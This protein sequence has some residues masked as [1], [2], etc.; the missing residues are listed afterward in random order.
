MDDQ[1]SS[2]SGDSTKRFSAKRKLA[3][4]QR[5]VRGQS[6]EAVSRNLNVPFHQ[7]SEW[8]DKVLL[9]AESALRERGRDA[10]DDEIA[11]LQAKVAEY[12]SAVH[13]PLRRSFTLSDYDISDERTSCVRKP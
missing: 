1:N 10:R 7:V 9:G 6:L 3:A 11:R 12:C 5:L 2:T 8:R 13:T 4:V